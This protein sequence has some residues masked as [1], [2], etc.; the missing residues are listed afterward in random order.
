MLGK[1]RG[2]KVGGLVVDGLAG[3]TISD[4]EN[5]A[6]AGLGAPDTLGEHYSRHRS[7]TV[8]FGRAE[9]RLPQEIVVYD[10]GG[11]HTH[12]H[13]YAKPWA[14]RFGPSMNY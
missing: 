12:D 6:A 7:R 8:P 2:V 5:R 1:R 13:G 14:S 10:E 11:T 9:F 4:S 3:A